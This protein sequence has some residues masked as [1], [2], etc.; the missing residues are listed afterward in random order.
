MSDSL[1]GHM[2]NETII[3]NCKQTLVIRDENINIRIAESHSKIQKINRKNEI[4]ILYA[5]SASFLWYIAIE[6]AHAKCI[7][8][9][10]MGNEHI[11]PALSNIHMLWD[12]KSFGCVCRVEQYYCIYN[13]QFRTINCIMSW[14]CNWMSGG[15]FGIGTR[16]GRS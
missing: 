13:A 5:R 8:N 6:R 2:E 14:W 16:W 3:L 12:W 7:P 11:N 10:S 4:T 15:E 1:Y 9:L